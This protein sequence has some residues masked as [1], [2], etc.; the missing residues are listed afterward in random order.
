MDRFRFDFV[1][2]ERKCG[3]T[4]NDD[5]FETEPADVYEQVLPIRILEADRVDETSYT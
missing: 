3:L 2:G 1:R 5:E 4:V